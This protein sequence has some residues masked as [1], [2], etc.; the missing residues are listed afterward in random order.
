MHTKFP[1]RRTLEEGNQTGPKVFPSS[2]L[3]SCTCR[4]S[5]ACSGAPARRSA[6]YRACSPEANAGP[7]WGPAALGASG[8][9]RGGPAGSHLGLKMVGI[10]PVPFYPDFCILL[11]RFRIFGQIWNWYEIRDVKFENRTETVW[12]V[13]NHFYISRI[14]SGYP[15]FTN[16]VYSVF[17]TMCVA[18]AMNLLNFLSKCGLVSCDYILCYYVCGCE[19]DYEVVNY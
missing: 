8:P 19:L 9:H 1:P 15:I 16:S 11:A 3:C 6:N 2:L 14:L 18:T 5:H 7:L 17:T 4:R 13:S 10:N 12:L